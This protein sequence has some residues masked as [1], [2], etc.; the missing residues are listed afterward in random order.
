MRCNPPGA[1]VH[2]ISQT[3]IPE[4]VAISFSR[5]SSWPRDRTRVSCI[6][7]RLFTIWANRKTKKVKVAQSCPTLCGP[8]QNTGVLFPFS[9][10]SFQ[11][12]NWTR[13]SCIAG[14]FFTN[15]AIS[16]APRRLERVAHPF[17]SGSSWS[18]NWT[19][20]SC[21]AGRVFT[22]WAM[23][24]ALLN[25]YIL[26]ISSL[27]MV[28]QGSLSSPVRTM[29]M[30]CFWIPNRNLSREEKSL[31]KGQQNVSLSRGEMKLCVYVLLS[32]VHPYL[33]INSSPPVLL[34]P[35]I[36]LSF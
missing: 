32:G 35:P 27:L 30:Y 15:W 26:L 31:L 5:G 1:S 23:R 14:R 12:R 11:P 4:C 24:E 8:G 29:A 2:G 18:R 10:R 36:E 21:I 19:G 22:N 28:G 3:R 33:G 34:P 7:G 6:A 9:S 25:Q 20:V 13:A 16:K 17:S